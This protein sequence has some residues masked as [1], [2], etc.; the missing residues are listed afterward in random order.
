[1]GC[2]PPPYPAAPVI[3]KRLLAVLVAAALVAGAWAV[4]Q[5]LQGDDDAGAGG[6]DDPPQAADVVWCVT[7]LAVACEALEVAGYTVEIGDAGSQADQ[8]AAA[9]PPDPDPVAWI[10]LD[11][12]P[13]IVDIRREASR[14]PVRF[15]ASTAVAGTRLGLVGRTERMEVIAEACGQLTWRCLGEQAN[16][17][18]VD[19]GGSEAWRE[20]KPAHASPVDS[21]VGLL[22][23][24]QAAASWFAVEGVAPEAIN[25]IDFDGPFRTWF[26]TLERAIPPAAFAG[27]LTP[28][29]RMLGQPIF[30]VVGTTEAEAALAPTAAYSVTYPDPV[31]SASVVVATAEP[32]DLPDGDVRRVA[33]ALTGS[34]WTAPAAA[35][36]SGLPTAQVLIA[37]Q[38]LWKE[39]VGA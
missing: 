16:V 33:D 2:A 30:D 15:A 31:V 22:V 11:S 8:L 21:A 37:L 32:D 38:N 17:D 28:L 35:G 5:Q 34:G 3:V 20:V 4:R 29:E 14:L 39:V 1:V 19:I 26:T 10:T 18:W 6:G 25:P 36:P 9:T 12:W 27:P 23:L 24:G 13:S 7:E